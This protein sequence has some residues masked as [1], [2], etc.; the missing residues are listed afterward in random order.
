VLEQH[1]LQVRVE[2][3]EEDAASVDLLQHVVLADR[4]RLVRDGHHLTRPTEPQP[5]QVGR[6]RGGPGA[7]GPDRPVLQD[8]D[9]HP[10]FVEGFALGVGVGLGEGERA[11]RD[12]VDP[13]GGEVRVLR[14]GVQ[15]GEQAGL[16]RRVGDADRD[17]AGGAGVDR[18]RREQGG[19]L[20]GRVLPDRRRRRGE[21]ERVRRVGRVQ[22]GDAAGGVDVLEERVLHGGGHEAGR[23]DL[24]RPERVLKPGERGASMLSASTVL[25]SAPPDRLTAAASAHV[26]VVYARRT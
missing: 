24:P 20:R 12:P 25:S 6:A 21:H 13:G 7:V 22:Q 3:G 1:P 26:P 8:G 16:H 14:G 23:G 9:R 11:A 19:V 18:P 15:P 4:V 2:T 10:G 5:R 17:P